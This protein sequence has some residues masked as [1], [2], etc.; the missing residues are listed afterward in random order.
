MRILQKN[1]ESFCRMIKSR[2]PDGQS[3]SS[4]AW[5]EGESFQACAVRDQTGRTAPKAQS[6]EKGGK[7]DAIAGYSVLT[8][9]AVSLPFHA[10]IKRQRDGLI[11]RITND[12]QDAQTPEGARLDLRMVSAEEWRLT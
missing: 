8:A 11:L 12:G 9:R 1:M 6:I 2:M 5:T 3:C 4:G 10:V 7:P